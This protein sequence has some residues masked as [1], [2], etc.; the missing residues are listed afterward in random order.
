MVSW[1]Q[2]DNKQLT[3]WWARYCE[4]RGDIQRAL[5]CY[6]KAADTLSVVRIHCATQNYTVAE[7]Q[8]RDGWVQQKKGG[9]QMTTHACWTLLDAVGKLLGWVVQRGA[10]GL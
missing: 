7:D 1:L 3:V 6:E 8:V 9:G 2:P 5:D 10:P 4:S